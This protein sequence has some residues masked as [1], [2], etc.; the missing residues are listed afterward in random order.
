MAGKH[1]IARDGTK[2]KKF[3][4]RG[5]KIKIK[6]Q[7][8]APNVVLKLT[9]KNTQSIEKKLWKLTSR[10]PV[11]KA[12]ANRSH[13]RRRFGAKLAIAQKGMRSEHVTQSNGGVVENLNSSISKLPTL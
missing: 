1:L 4:Q 6:R 12:L 3:A 2:T 5:D 9:G 11:S 8:L 13:Q 7:G 10:P